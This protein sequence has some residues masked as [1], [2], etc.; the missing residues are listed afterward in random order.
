M[1]FQNPNDEVAIN[2]ASSQAIHKAQKAFAGLAE[3]MDVYNEGDVQALVD[4]I[5]K[6]TL[7]NDTGMGY[8]K[9]VTVTQFPETEEV[10]P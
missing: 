4:E 9:C 3:Q 8:P 1:I 10:E 2:N 5:R 7:Q 6:D